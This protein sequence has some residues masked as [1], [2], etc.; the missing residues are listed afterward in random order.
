[1]YSEEKDDKEQ[2]YKIY[3][4]IIYMYKYIGIYQNEKRIRR[5]SYKL[6][7]SVVPQLCPLRG[8]FCTGFWSV[9]VLFFVSPLFLD[10]LVV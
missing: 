1:M 9:P 8:V 2:N 4:Y 7:H 6:I 10:W 5:F 3:I